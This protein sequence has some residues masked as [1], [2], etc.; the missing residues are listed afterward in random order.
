MNLHLLDPHH[1]PQISFQDFEMFL[2]NFVMSALICCVFF[3]EGSHVK[4]KSIRADKKFRKIVV[5]PV[6]P[7]IKSRKNSAKKLLIDSPKKLLTLNNKIV[8]DFLHKEKRY[9]Q[10]YL[11]EYKKMIRSLLPEAEMYKD[12][13]SRDLLVLPYETKTDNSL[14]SKKKI[15]LPVCSSVK[16]KYWSKVKVLQKEKRN[17]VTLKQNSQT[18]ARVVEKLMEAKKN[19]DKETEFFRHA[20]HS[21]TK[22]FTAF[23]CSAKPQG[24]SRKERYSIITDFVDGD[25]SHVMAAVATA[26]QLRFMVAQFFNSVI[27]LHKVGFIHC[28]LSP[29]NVMVTKEYEV[30]LIDFGM[31]V[32]IGQAYGHRG[33]PYTRAPELHEMCPG[34]IDVS[35]DWWAFGCTVSMW[36]YY[37]YNPEMIQ[38][39]SATYHFT[40][41]KLYHK[42]EF[43][44]GKFPAQFPKDLRRFLSLFLTIDPE[45]RTFSTDRLQN[46]IRNHEYFNGFDWSV[47]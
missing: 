37:H 3:I 38:D 12:F 24:R 36:F 15:T 22:Y 2:R 25:K 9:N 11:V 7:K 18:G 4:E 20:H 19:Y 27:E 43:R 28:D 14:Y 5:Y 32:P 40:P 10:K 16:E 33:S 23:I 1:A 45:K 21:S 26:D 35:I 13:N 8:V 44:S 17:T 29:A 41:M 6:T 42:N 47:A 31:A 34:K 46:M 30:K 39:T